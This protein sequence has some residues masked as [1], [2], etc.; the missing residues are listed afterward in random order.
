MIQTDLV[1]LTHFSNQILDETLPIVKPDFDAIHNLIKDPSVRKDH[2]PLAITWIGHATV[3]VQ[4]DG[5]TF[6]TDPIFSD[7]ASPVSFFGP[8]RYR[9]PAC[10]VQELPPDLDAV[11][12]SHSHYDHLDLDSVTSLNERFG[13]NLRWF[14]PLGLSQLLTSV[15]CQNVTEMDWW[16]ESIVAKE[17]KEPGMGRTEVTF[18]FTPT[19]HWSK[20]SPSDDNKSLW[21]SWAVIGPRHRFYFAGDTG[22]CPVFKEIGRVYGPFTAAAIPIGAYE[23]RWFMAPAH[24]D[25]ED[26]VNIHTDIGSRFS[27][28]IHWGTFKLS[29]EYYLDP[30]VLLTQ[31]LEENNLTPGSFVTF[32]HGQTRLVDG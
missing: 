3:V 19:Q 22:Y 4:M 10:S 2:L 15:G 31:A 6:I 28:G 1:S 16:E 25:P 18:A 8:K 17:R 12:I 29:D 14:V 7:R 11:I 24:V 5:V 30:P 20:R 21:G 9:D 23:P 13:G 32:R 26:A 27:L